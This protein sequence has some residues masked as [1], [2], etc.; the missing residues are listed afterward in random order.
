MTINS[1][2]VSG[3]MGEDPQ[4]IEGER[5]T[6]GKGRIAVYQGRDKP[7]IWFNVL[8]WSQ[9]SITDLMKAKKGDKVVVSGR[10]TLNEWTDK[11]GATRQDLGIS[12]ESIEVYPKSA[13][14]EEAI[15]GPA[16]DDDDQIPW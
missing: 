5:K 2:T 13:P 9:W 14:R 15:P 10:L 3:N 8:A 11:S 7:S 12:C 1:L 16:D 6:F 4:T